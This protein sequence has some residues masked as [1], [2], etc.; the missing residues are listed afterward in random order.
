MKY[1]TILFCLFISSCMFV[2]LYS[3]PDDDAKWIDKTTG[4]D[5]PMEMLKKCSEYASFSII[6]RNTLSDRID[7]E[8]INHIGKIRQIKGQCLYEDEF[9][10]KVKMFSSYCSRLKDVCDAYNKYRK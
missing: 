8:Y 9:V 3:I 5:A 10:F 1:M 2:P 6:G 7:T 4:E